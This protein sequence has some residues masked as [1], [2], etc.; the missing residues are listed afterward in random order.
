MKTYFPGPRNHPFGGSGPPKL[1]IPGS[2]KIISIMILIR[3]W[4]YT[5]D[6]GAPQDRIHPRHGCAWDPAHPGPRCTSGT[7]QPKFD[8]YPGT[9][10]TKTNKQTNK[11]VYIYN[12][13][14][15]HFDHFPT[16]LG[17][18]TRSNGSGSKYGAER[19]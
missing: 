3:S 13:S 16:K 10:E 11:Y 4:G 15:G 8:R 18:E 5:R 2:G 17:P 6:P 12:F 14:F 9:Q 1:M 7:R 19:K